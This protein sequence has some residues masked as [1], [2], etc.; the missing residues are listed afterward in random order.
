MGP[1]TV[2]V[3]GREHPIAGM[4]ARLV[5]LLTCSVDRWVS[6]DDLIDALWAGAPPD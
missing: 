3:S 1:V 6:V 4:A 2:V 5:T